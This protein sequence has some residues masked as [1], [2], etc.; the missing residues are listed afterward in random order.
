MR[1]ATT[2][3]LGVAVL[4][5]GALWGSPAAKGAD[6]P[7]KVDRR[8]E[9]IH[10]SGSRL[11]VQIDDVEK[12]DVARL[13]LA[14]ERGAVVESVEEDSPAAKAGLQKDDVILRFQGESVQSARQ[15]SRLVRET[16]AGRT[17]SIE[18]SRAGAPQKVAATLREGRHGGFDMGDLGGDF[19]VAVPPVPP[20]PPVPP[21]SADVFKWK[22]KEG[23]AFAFHDL[24]GRGPR[25]L[26]ISFQDVSGQLAKFLHAP[27]ET[28]VLVVSVDDDSAAEKAGLK[29][30]D[31][32][33]RFDGREIRDTDDLRDEVRRATSGKEITIAVQR[34]GKVVELRAT[35]RD[36]EERRPELEETT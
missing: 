18:V 22:G 7:R 30:G 26:G 32:I 34:E 3:G 20:I 5:T 12:G 29:A 2:L 10:L 16:P 13:K 8:V 19:D 17:V 33:V 35:L 6:S 24:M 27:S 25:R 36:R 9:V 23:H 11:G 15:L 28:A 21:M 1:R 31:L 14:E 4:A